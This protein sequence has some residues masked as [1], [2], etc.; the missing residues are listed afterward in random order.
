MPMSGHRFGQGI[1]NAIADIREKVV[2]E[3]WFGRNLTSPRDLQSPAPEVPKSEE[4]SLAH[5]FGWSRG[6]DYTPAPAYEPEHSHD[7]DR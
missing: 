1:A 5:R 7:I 2:E 3:P 4:P 6:E